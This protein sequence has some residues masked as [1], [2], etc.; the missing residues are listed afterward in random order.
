MEPIIAIV[1]VLIG[2]ALG[3]A[4]LINQGNEALVERL[5]RYHRKLAP[6]LNFI[7]PLLDQIVMEDTTREQ[8][9]DIEPQKA[10]T[11]DNIYLEVDGVVYWKIRDMERSFYQID[12][13]EQAL[14]N[15]TAT[16]L[17]EIVA[18]NSLEE[19]NAARAD[20]N[21]AL[22]DE[23]NQITTEWGVQIIRVDIQRITPPESVQKSMEEQRAAEIKSRAAILE[24]D[25]ERQ[26]AI[27][28]AEG[29][30]TSMK[31]ISEALRTIPDS[32]EVLRYLESQEQ[33][34]ASYKLSESKNAKVV[35]V[36]ANAREAPE[37]INRISLS[38]ARHE[39]PQDEQDEE[40][41]S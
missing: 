27:M 41:S 9:L 25:G 5:G 1:L 21:K 11:K 29:T 16:T 10:I 19:T 35:F 3:S 38:E 6:G 37:M 26:A 30:K 20:M 7:V 39:I 31:I 18:Q 24:A 8:V 23:L 32:Q 17:R 4:K 33:I 28:K 14:T 2:Y 40:I 36:N 13:L 34:N 22:L 15:L 12:N